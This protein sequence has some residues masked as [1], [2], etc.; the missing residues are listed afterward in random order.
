M[1]HRYA[2][3]AVSQSAYNEVAHLLRTAKY[4]HAFLS[5]GAIDMHGIALTVDATL[6]REASMPVG[7]Q[8]LVLG[9][10]E[11]CSAFVVLGWGDTLPSNCR[12][13]YAEPP[14]PKD[15]GRAFEIADK[16]M[17]ELLESELYKYT[18]RFTFPPRAAHGHDEAREAFDWLQPRGY[19]ELAKDKDGEFIKVLR[20]PGELG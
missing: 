12:A 11:H 19:V 1:T 15:T 7:Y 6:T 17:F 8:R 20:R 9:K 3:L 18:G 14:L 10:W 16:A 13:V 2:E 5:S 4:D